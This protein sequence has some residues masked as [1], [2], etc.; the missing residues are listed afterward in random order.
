VVREDCCLQWTAPEFRQ[1]CCAGAEQVAIAIGKGLNSL[2]LHIDRA[3]YRTILDPDRHDH[4]RTG[5]AKSGQVP[6][7]LSH[8]LHDHRCAALDRCS[9]QSLTARKDRIGR[10]ARTGPSDDSDVSWAHVVKSD[11]TIIS[12]FGDGSCSSRCLYLARLRTSEKT[13][14]FPQERC[15]LW[16]HDC[17]RHPGEVGHVLLSKNHI[18]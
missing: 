12:S 4:L 3:Y 6:D 10:C 13:V 5:R 11:P 9:I 7:I 8:I 14:Q 18:A 2:A 17:A 15:E 1:S 16:P